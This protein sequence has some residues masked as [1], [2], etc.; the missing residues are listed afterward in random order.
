[1]PRLFVILLF[2]ISNIVVAQ[3]N[4]QP[5]EYTIIAIFGTGCG[6]LPEPPRSMLEAGIYAHAQDKAPL[7]QWLHS[8][9]S[10]QHVFGFIGLYFM[11]RDGLHLTADEKKAMKEVQHSK[12]LIAY[13]RGCI[14]PPAKPVKRVLTKRRLK[15]MYAWYRRQVERGVF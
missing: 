9:F 13:C 6:P 2:F 11:V 1:M 15:S 4:T 12:T 3:S 5:P 8:P 10:Q 7:L 14:V